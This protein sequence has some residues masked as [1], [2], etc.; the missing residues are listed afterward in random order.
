MN[1]IL[2]GPPG[3][4]KGTQAEFISQ[5]FH[6]PKISTGDMLRAA[7]AH[8]PELQAIMGSGQLVSDQKIIEILFARIKQPDCSRGFLLDGFPRTIAQAEA[9]QKAGI[10]IKAVIR[11]QVP[12]QEIIKRMTGR[13]M[14][15]PSGRTYHVI[16]NPP[17]VAGLDDL[18]GEP[19]IHRND[20]TEDT[21]R[22]RLQIYHAQTEPLAMWY[23]KYLSAGH[24]EFFDVNGMQDVDQ[25]REIIKK[26]LSKL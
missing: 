12:D 24:G 5:D 25:V 15:Q 11:L 13:L 20:D 2:M 1:I 10:T 8:D 18:T 23:K 14:H 22:K 4:G 3:A 26:H 19:L 7:Q 16:F 6:I 17:Q 21:V 9:L